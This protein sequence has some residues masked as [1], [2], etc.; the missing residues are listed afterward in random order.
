MWYNKETT[1]ICE[2]KANERG[3]QMQ[4]D[5]LERNEFLLKI[6]DK[7]NVE[8]NNVLIQQELYE[9]FMKCTGGKVY[10]YRYFDKKKYAI[11]NVKTGTLYCSSPTVFNDPFDC[12]I[13][14]DIQ[15]LL[16][17]KSGLEE[18]TVS[19]LF[20]NFLLVYSGQAKIDDFMPEEQTSIRSWLENERMKG[21]LESAGNFETEQDLIEYV[22]SNRDL[23][24]D[25]LKGATSDPELSKALEISRQSIVDMMNK[26]TAENADQLSANMSVVDIAKLNGYT[27]DVDEISLAAMISDQCNPEKHEDV[28]R[29][30]DTYQK[31]EKELEERISK[32]FLVGCLADD[33]KNRLMWSHYGDSH[34][35]F[36]IE[37]DY[38]GFDRMDIVPFPVAYT[39]ERV[40]IPWKAAITKDPEDIANAT[41]VFMQALLTKDEAWS[42]EREWRILIHKKDNANLKM[43][44]ISCIYIGALCKEK[45]KKKLLKLARKLKIPVKQR[46]I[47]RGEYALHVVDVNY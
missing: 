39:H 41:K 34:K 14:L 13:G 47:D 21:L 45:H 24:V 18:E 44:P 37:Y 15:S 7:S 43:P 2:V 27:A 22:L 32:L 40:K 3:I 12:K 26:I 36:C 1:I 4:K 8:G 17:A 20:Q 28:V 11:S 30:Q 29:M 5:L 6:I 35:G 16:I 42:Y 38:T 33:Y 9:F 23:I 10:K 25:I 19:E 31:L 46:I